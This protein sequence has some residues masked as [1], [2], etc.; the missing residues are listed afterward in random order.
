M[1]KIL[2]IIQA[3]MSSVRLP[4][5]VM[6]EVNNGQATFKVPASVAANFPDGS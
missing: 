1:N 2:C 3:R 5:K 4:W 6:M